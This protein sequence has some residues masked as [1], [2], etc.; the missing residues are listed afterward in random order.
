MSSLPA[1]YLTRLLEWIGAFVLLSMMTL[2]FVD[3]S[4][5]HE[6]LQ[7]KVADVLASIRSDVQKVL[8]G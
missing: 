3:E 2:T 7:K 8:A 4:E 5:I 6:A 1:R